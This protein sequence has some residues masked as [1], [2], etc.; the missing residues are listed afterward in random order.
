VLTD[1]R[2]KNPL[3]GIPKSQLLRDV[4]DFAAK[5]DLHDI[6]PQLIKGAL[7]AQAPSHIDNIHELDDEDRRVILEEVSHKWRHPRALYF[8]IFLN[9]VAAAIQGWDQTGSYP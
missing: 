4:E 8:T 1:Y 9:S 7:I 6:T 5:Y 3:V 2:I